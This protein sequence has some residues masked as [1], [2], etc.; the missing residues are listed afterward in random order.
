MSNLE[1][2]SQ[3]LQSKTISFLRFP[4]IVAVVLLHARF[5]EIVFNGVD[6][7]KG[8]NFPVYAF[9]SYFLSHIIAR[10]AVPLFYFISGFLFFYKTI[11]FNKLAYGSKLKKRVKTLLIPYIF[12]NLAVIVFFFLSQTFLT[13]LVSGKN[14]LICD[15]TFSDWLWAFW[16]TNKINS[17]VTAVGSG[18]YPICY[19]F[20]FIRDLMVVMLFSPLV[21]FLLKKLR[22]Y[23][24]I[25]LGILWLSGYWFHIVGFSIT[26]FFFFSAGAYFSIYGK[27]FVAL[28]K[29]FLPAAAVLFV[30]TTIVEL[31]FK[32]QAWCNYIK[33]L[34][35]LFGIVLTIAISAYFIG[36]RKWKVNTFLSDSS[37]FI[38]AY[39]AIVLA[40]IVKFLFKVI[41][42]HS[43][44]IVVLLYL[45]SPA[46]VV[47][48]GLFL[49]YI[50]KKY[51]PKTTSFITGGR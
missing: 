22:Q 19:Q 15:Y 13:E 10:M 23:A 32:E 38:Y 47:F 20:W 17:S 34:N 28:M 24:V 36:K 39:H 29:P 6:L 26:A 18:A 1:I 31:W 44:G 2:T 46:I 37:F 25:G 50:L 48:I 16:N 14:K 4:L 35:I 30:V 42:P 5:N 49:Y 11:S 43:D 9:L 12:W 51:L 40:F 21:Y 3:E 8:G 33:G 41:Q 27:N 45:V 7:M